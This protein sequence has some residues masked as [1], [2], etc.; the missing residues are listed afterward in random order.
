MMRKLGL[1]AVLFVL[2]FSGCT[3]LEDELES[4]SLPRA[5][6]QRVQEAIG[7]GLA[8]T[9]DVNQNGMIDGFEWLVLIQNAVR[10]WGETKGE[11]KDDK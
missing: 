6:L 3:T 9:P 8:A 2:V 4:I 10:A 1:L 7:V 5:D 11:A